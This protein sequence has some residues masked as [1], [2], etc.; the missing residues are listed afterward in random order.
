[1]VKP[2]RVI[3]TQLYNTTLTVLRNAFSH[4]KLSGMLFLRVTLSKKIEKHATL[5]VLC[6]HLIT[7]LK[8]KV[9]DEILSFHYF[10]VCIS[11]LL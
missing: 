5:S 6:L 3:I 4:S 1:M 11:F 10:Q 8:H 7:K 9:S 2:Y